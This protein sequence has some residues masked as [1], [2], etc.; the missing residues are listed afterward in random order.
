MHGATF[1]GTERGT[2]SSGSLRPRTLENG[3]AR[4]WTARGWARGCS[5]RGL[6]GR[7]GRLDRRLVHRARTRLRH[8]H[9]RRRSANGRCRPRRSCCC[10][11]RGGGRRLRSGRRGKCR[12]RR[13]RWCRRLGRR[14][15]WSGCRSAGRRGRWRRRRSNHRRSRSWLWNDQPW[16]GRRFGCWLWRRRRFRN[17]CGGLGLDG[18][19]G[20]RNRLRRG[21][22]SSGLLL[23]GNQLHYVA[24]LRNMREIDLRLDLVVAANRAS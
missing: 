24:G 5:G 19:C 21:R 3:L 23:L 9:A 12:R 1:A 17:G 11:R 8:D 7:C 16:S 18:R 10:R 4:D 15:N 2:R 22:R 20:R 6:P 14:G 13:D